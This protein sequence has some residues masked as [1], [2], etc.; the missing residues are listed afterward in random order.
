[1]PWHDLAEM[2]I[3]RQIPPEL[4]PCEPATRHVVF[5][6]FPDVQLLDVTGPFQVLASANALVPDAA[7]PPYALKVVA[8]DPGAIASSSGLTLVAD[9]LPPPDQPI[10]TLIIAG[11]AGTVAVC[12]NPALLNWI[13]QRS[14]KARRVA[15]VCTGAFILAAAGLLDGR[16]ATTHWSRCAELAAAFPSIQV[17]PDPIYI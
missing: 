15:S 5:L 17:E 11:G 13:A 14:A 7:R 12:R 2:P 8:A 1:M 9:P 10:D 16:R 4:Y 6:A 3:E